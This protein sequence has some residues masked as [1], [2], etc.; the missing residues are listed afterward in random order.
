T[1]I[2]A[3]FRALT[4]PAAANPSALP[5][6]K[7]LS[8]TPSFSAMANLS[9]IWAPTRNILGAHLFHRLRLIFRRV[10]LTPVRGRLIFPPTPLLFRNKQFFIPVTVSSCTHNYFCLPIASPVRSGQP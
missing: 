10:G 6:A 1:L 5:P 2:P 4:Q 3:I 8:G 9:P 7:V